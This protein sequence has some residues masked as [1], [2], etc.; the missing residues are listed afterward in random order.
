MQHAFH[1]VRV[2]CFK[3]QE[4]AVAMSFLGRTLWAPARATV[5][6]LVVRAAPDASGVTADRDCDA[7]SAQVTGV[8]LPTGGMLRKDACDGVVSLD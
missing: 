5:P 7:E 4:A 8:T 1:D 6:G 3:S 2:I